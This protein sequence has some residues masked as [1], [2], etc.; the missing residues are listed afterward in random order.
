MPYATRI[1]GHVCRSVRIL[2]GCEVTLMDR[3]FSSELL[4]S[5]KHRR[6]PPAGI[7]P[8]LPVSIGR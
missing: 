2:E 6:S 8:Q 1:C 3:D 5:K 7:P 4:A